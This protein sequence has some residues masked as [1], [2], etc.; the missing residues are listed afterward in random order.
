MHL[1]PGPFWTPCRGVFT[2]ILSL[3]L[4]VLLNAS[5]LKL[6]KKKNNGIL[7]TATWSSAGENQSVGHRLPRRREDLRLQEDERVLVSPRREERGTNWV[8][9]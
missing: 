1:C 4:K 5:W 6:A 7:T 8:Q 3:S 9:V 2:A